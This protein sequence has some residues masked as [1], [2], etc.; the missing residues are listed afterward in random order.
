MLAHP[1]YGGGMV[2]VYN[3][4]LEPWAQRSLAQ[5]LRISI[6][7]VLVLDADKRAAHAPYKPMY[8]LPRDT[9]AG[10][11][12]ICSLACTRERNGERDE[13]QTINNKRSVYIVFNSFI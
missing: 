13:D 9:Q 11:P 4:I 5:M 7:S 12:S 3:Y 2:V 8:S 1:F 6:K 10:L